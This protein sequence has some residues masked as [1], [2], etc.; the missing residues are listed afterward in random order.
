MGK[1]SVT[2]VRITYLITKHLSNKSTT[3]EGRRS[4][5]QQEIQQAN[6]VV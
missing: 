4:D 1:G 3:R 2:L 5:A 6:E